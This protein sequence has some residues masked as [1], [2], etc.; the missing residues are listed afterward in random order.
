MTALKL[1][2]IQT[3]LLA[4]LN[5]KTPVRVAGNR[6]RTLRVLL[7]GGL[8][9]AKLFD[10]GNGY[11]PMTGY[12]LTPKGMTAL[13]LEDGELIHAPDCDRA[14]AFDRPCTCGAGGASVEAT[15]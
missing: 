3:G 8:V 13:T 9:T 5:D 7:R 14:G 15:P 11:P 1:S 2:K 12:L 10:A 6:H 4:S